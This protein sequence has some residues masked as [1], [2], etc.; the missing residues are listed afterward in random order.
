MAEVFVPP[1]PKDEPP[2]R[3]PS[4]AVID[5]TCKGRRP[6]EVALFPDLNTT[7]PYL[8]RFNSVFPKF[9]VDSTHDSRAFIKTISIQL[10]NHNRF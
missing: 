2:T 7:E 10:T 3:S 1:L 8:N 4:E 5:V 6:R 9:V